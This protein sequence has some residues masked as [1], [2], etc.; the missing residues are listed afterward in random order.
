MCVCG[1]M[2]SFWEGSIAGNRRERR[3]DCE[4]PSKSSQDGW[5]MA[6]CPPGLEEI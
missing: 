6:R 2:E 5:G 1:I 3:G 4:P